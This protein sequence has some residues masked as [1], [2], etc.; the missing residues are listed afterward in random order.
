MMLKN[1]NIFLAVAVFIGTHSFGQSALTLERCQQLAAE[2][3]PLVAQYDLID[4]AADFTLSNISTVY[5]PQISLNGQASYQTDVTKMRLKPDVQ[6]L[7][8]GIGAALGTTLSPDDLIETM[9]KDQYKAYIEAAQV[10]W[11]GGQTSGGKKVVRATSEVEK[12]K[13]AVSLYA[14]SAKIN[15]LYFGILSA[16]EQEKLLDAYY[17][18]LQAVEDMANAALKNGVALTSDVDLV[19]V[20]RLNID[21]KKI[22]LEAAK[23][24]FL[25][26]LSAFIGVKLDE[27]TALQIPADVAAHTNSNLR[28]ELQLFSLQRSLH[29]AQR[30][31]ITAQNMPTLGLFVQGG[32]GSPALNMLDPAFRPYAIG[33]VRFT[34]NFGNLYSRKNDLKTIEN[35][36]QMVDVQEQTFLFNNQL[37]RNS[38]LPEIEKYKKLMDKDEEIVRLRANVKR[39]SESKYRNGVYEMKDLIADTNAENLAKQT[40]SLHYIQYLTAVYDYKLTTN[41]K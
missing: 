32:Y 12:Q 4:R 20:E 28:P 29:N 3:Y 39:T 11:D 2:H 40:K 30:Q 7:L 31:T 27:N 19:K 18:D 26:V 13:I 35:N 10:I 22:E 5:L 16:N 41:N 25:Q 14:I 8:D 24:A 1:K 23:S 17:S 6:R 9:H 15:Q 37:E 36:L 33:G 34:W 38:L 21:Q